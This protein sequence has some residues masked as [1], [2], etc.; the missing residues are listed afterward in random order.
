MP[1]DDELLAIRCQLGE[2]D[3][4]DAL[5][6]RWHEPLWSYARRVTGSADAADD[7]VQ[8]IWIRVMRGL[9]RLK[10]PARLRAWIFSI[11]RRALMDR[12][13]GQ[14]ASPAFSDMDVEDLS[15]MEVVTDL[16]E[17]LALMHEQLAGLPVIERDALALFYLQELSM[18]E[19]SDVLGVPVGTIKSRLHRARRLLQARMSEGNR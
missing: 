11:A 18:A 4:F 12:L 6:A 5:I 19:M 10:D 13:R 8:D 3:A 16:S 14:Y 2:R 17:D 15:A 1:A 7:T 9:P